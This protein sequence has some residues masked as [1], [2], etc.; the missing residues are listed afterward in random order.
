MVICLF[1]IIYN[2]WM[3]TYIYITYL[4]SQV[5][6]SYIDINIVV[7]EDTQYNYLIYYDMYC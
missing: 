4:F 2:F 6:L 3:Y 5:L 7:I 1:L